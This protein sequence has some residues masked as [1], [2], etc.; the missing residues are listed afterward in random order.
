MW[1]TFYSLQIDAHLKLKCKDRDSVKTETVMN[2]FTKEF[3]GE[4]GVS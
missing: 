3:L 4:G 1:K 2:D